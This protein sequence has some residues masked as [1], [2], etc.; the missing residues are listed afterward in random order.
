MRRRL[1][2]TGAAGLLVAGI[3][4]LCFT[5][6][7]TAEPANNNN[8]NARVAKAAAPLPIGHVILFSS[9]VG[10]FQR[11][12]D[13][14]GNA[15]VDLS[16]PGSD[17]N[18]LLKSLVLQ[19]LGGGQISTISYDSPDPIEKTLKSFALDLTNNPTFG[20]ILNQARGEKIELTMQQS[21]TAQPGTITGTIVGMESQRQPHGKDQMIDVE[22]LNLLCTEG[23]RSVPLAQVLRVRFL[24]PVLENEFRRA[25]E[26]LAGKH[27]TQK[28][29]VSLGFTGN[30]KRPVRVGYVVESP[31]WKTSYRLV[32]DL[33][34]APHLQGWAVV[35]N[36]TDEDW[37]DVRMALISGRPISFQMNL[38]QP[39]FIPRPTM[40]PELFASLR[41]PTYS[42]ALANPAVVAGGG[43]V[44][45][46]PPGFGGGGFQG[47]QPAFGINNSIN[48]GNRYQFGNLGGQ[49]GN[50]G[51]GQF[52]M[53]G[54]NNNDMTRNNLAFQQI[55][56]N[57]FYN[58]NKLTYEEL[59]KRRNDLQ[60]SKGNARQLGAQLA[61][62]PR[63]SVSSVANAEEIGDHFIYDIDQKVSLAR[64]KSAM[65]P[66]INQQVEA[67]KVS[68]FNEG[69]HTK[70][71]L[72]GLKFKNTTAHPLTQ[73]PITVYEGNNYAGDTRVMDL[74]PQEERL[75]SY[76]MDL[77]TE[78]KV[79]G[80]H[81][82]VQLVAVK[83]VKGIMR[84]S[85]KLQDTRTYIVKNRSEHD[86]VLLIEHPYREDW[87]LITPEKA[88]ER[89]RD[90]YR[91]QL[92]LAAGK[93]LTHQVVEEQVRV[94][95]LAINASDDKA[96]RVFLNSNVTSPK[97]K[98]ALQEAM[99]LR[100]KLTE[101]QRELAQ[102]EKQ[103]KAITEDQGRL[104]ANMREVP[105]TSAAYKRY[106]EKFD[107]QET[108]I[109]RL[110]ALIKKQQEAEKAQQKEYEDY[111]ANLNVE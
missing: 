32:L 79:E 86:R 7:T 16:F 19:D 15:N 51:G 96:V 65:L 21:S 18:D 94:D 46:P 5:R 106:L 22:Q 107:T 6:S 9:G 41:P 31:I 110:Q 89:S 59:Q 63:A 76:A 26:V 37:K 48:P 2:L 67:S 54:M 90:V 105:Q 42:G 73:G 55:D 44:P 64:Q 45:Q 10:Y 33:N 98:A 70:F 84:T 88:T 53:Q 108:E 12:G 47:G 3:T 60:N 13:V 92:K 36:T 24:N 29:S 49:F 97:V 71:P 30:G 87:K 66:I 40:E 75:V 80:K 74:Q 43:A 56:N 72:L 99:S 8:N 77:G 83:V 111:L 11:E 52:G 62:D 25:L 104:R 23:M 4:G 81:A 57:N 34:K 68:I 58:Q 50:Q 103:L 101:T 91:F 17:V 28:K 109:E 78:V 20:Q 102:V 39:L 93:S 38:Y 85:H 69:V 61:M 82:P 35:E 14:E 27:D 100:G 1:I 95:T